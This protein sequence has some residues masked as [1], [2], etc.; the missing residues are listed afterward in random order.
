M[1]VYLP[2]YSFGAETAGFLKA[3]ICNDDRTLGFSALGVRAGELL[4]PVQLAMAAGLPYTLR[5]DLILTQPT[6]AE[7]LVYL[8]FSVLN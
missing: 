3:P 4:G 6:L 8:S 7:G 2:G 5:R 1:K